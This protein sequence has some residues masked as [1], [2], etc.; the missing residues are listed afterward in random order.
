MRKETIVLAPAM[1]QVVDESRSALPVS[2]IQVSLPE[3]SEEQFGLIEPRG[4]GWREKS[5]HPGIVSQEGMSVRRNVTGTTVPDEVNPAGVP[6]NVQEV[7]KRWLQMLT[8]ISI[9][10]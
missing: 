3:G 5:P 6:V 10:T 4:V 7:F 1:L 2:A 8:I 9:Q